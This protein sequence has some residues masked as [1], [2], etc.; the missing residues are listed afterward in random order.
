MEPSGTIKPIGRIVR[1]VGHLLKL[2]WYML[3]VYSIPPDDGL[4]ICPE[5]CRG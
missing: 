2:N 1:Q 4:Q 5:K 3:Y